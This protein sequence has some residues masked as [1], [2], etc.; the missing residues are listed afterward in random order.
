MTFV[1]IRGFFKD[2]L[3]EREIIITF[4]EDDER[5]KS[6]RTGVFMEW[7]GL[8]YELPALRARGYG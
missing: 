4:R 8:T 3:E 5:K 2:I 6:S 7:E 1:Y